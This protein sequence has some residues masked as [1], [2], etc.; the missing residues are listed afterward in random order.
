MRHLMATILFGASLLVA[1]D[2]AAGGSSVEFAVTSDRDPD[3]FSTPDDMKYD[4]KV[5]HEFDSRVIIGG[6]FTYTDNAFRAQASQNLEGTLGY[7]VPIGSVFSLTGSAGMGEYWRQNPGTA[8]PYYVLRIKADLDLSRNI[9]WNVI[10]YRFRD[11][12]DP[13]DD[14]NTPQV[15]TGITFRINERSSIS[16]SVKRNW[17]DGKASSTGVALGFKQDF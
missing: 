15:A 17:T 3:K 7:R 8:F 12:F 14:Y 9:T 10:S 6:L 13:R 11:S 16:A 5:A 2:A 4:L 1:A